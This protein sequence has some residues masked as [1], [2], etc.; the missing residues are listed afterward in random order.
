MLLS[1]LAG[2]PPERGSRQGRDT[3]LALLYRETVE[4]VKQHVEA[5]GERRHRT[6]GAG[7]EPAGPASSAT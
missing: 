3:V 1:G 6:P 2:F 5:A 4:G 7:I